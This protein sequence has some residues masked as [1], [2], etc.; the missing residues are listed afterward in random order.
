LSDEQKQIRVDASQELLNWP[1]EDENF[2]KN[3]ITG[4]ETWIYGYDVET[5]AQSSQWVS[6]GS[7]RPK[8][9]DKCSQTLKS[10]WQFFIDSEG[11]VQHEFLPQGKRVTRQ[12]YLEVM[13]HLHEAIR[14]KK[15]DASRSNRWMLHADN[16]PAYITINPSVFGGTRG[17]SHYTSSL[18]AWSRTSGL[19]LFTKLKMSLKGRSFES[20]DSIREN[21]LADLRSVPNEAFKKCFEEWK[22][23]W[24]RCIQ[25][26]V[27]Y[28]EDDM[29][30]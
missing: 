16:A 5:K 2:L 8:K 1:N 26:G 15:P 3:I 18:L 13:K 23:C 27:D 29:A 6:Q 14:K 19:F 22:K 28:F 7:P 4:E 9:Q 25:S 11:V 20:S 30:E 17:N 12:Y 10:C 24:E 21:S